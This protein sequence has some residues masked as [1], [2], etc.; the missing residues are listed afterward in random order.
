MYESLNQEKQSFDSLLQMALGIAHEINNPNAAVGM[1]VKNLEKLFHLLNKELAQKKT[2]NFEKIGPYSFDQ[3]FEKIYKLLK[4]IS[5]ASLR[6]DVTAKKFKE[7]DQSNRQD[8]SSICIK[9]LVEE[10]VTRHQFLA[11][12]ITVEILAEKNCENLKISGHY[13]KLEQSF[14]NLILNA[15]DALKEKYD[16]AL[17]K[18]HLKVSLTQDQK[19]IVI[20]IRDNGPG[21]KKDQMAKVFD[22][23]FST[24]KG[25][26][27]GLGLSLTRKIIQEHGGG[28]EVKSESGEY[29]EFCVKLPLIR[30]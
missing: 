13:L 23:Y 17:A 25:K 14:S 15:F 3:F 12:E 5:Q 22:F 26:G 18:A 19:N 30:D 11:P 1:S 7:I 28:I 4:L 8:K 27:D 2:E 21:I 10:V 16:A 20:C 24:K 29:C 6:I 9:D